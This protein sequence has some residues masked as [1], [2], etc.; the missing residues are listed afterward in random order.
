MQYQPEI[1]GLRALAVLPVILFHAGFQGF[2]G[3]FIGV[4]IFFV[5]S[6]YLITSIILAE[7]EAGTFTLASFYER[8]ARRILPALFFVMALCLPFAWFWLLPYDLQNFSQSLV[9]VPTFA[10][11]IF[12]YQQ[13]GYFDE[14]ASIKPLLHTW[15]L[16]VEEQY[17]LVFP[18][19]IVLTWRFGKTLILKCLV[20]VFILSLA[21]AHWSF[22]AHPYF[23]FFLL[24]T[25]G[26]ELLIGGILA[27]YF[28]LGYKRT[29]N[30][31]INEFGSL[32]GIVLIIH[33]IFLF[34]NATPNPSFYTLVPTV[35]TV[36]IIYFAT[37]QTYT[38][39]LLGSKFFVGLGLI[40]YSAYLY[41][42][43]LFAFAKQRSI[44]EPSK[45][46]IGLLV[47]V[48]FC[49][50]Y[51]SWRFI[52]APFRNKGRINRKQLFTFCILAS[53]SFVLIGL[54][55]YLNKGFPK[56]VNES[57]LLALAKQDD[58]NPREK[59]CQASDSKWI[60]PN[61]SCVMGDRNK[62]QVVLLG[63]SHANAIAYELGNSLEVNGIGMRQLT[64]DGCPPLFDV[65]HVDSGS[66]CYLYSDAAYKFVAQNKSITHIVISLRWTAYL[67]GYGFNNKEGGIEYINSRIDVISEGKLQRNEDEKRREVLK[68]IYAKT[69]KKYMDLGRQVILVYQVPEV[70]WNVP[71]VLAKNKFFNKNTSEN[72][73]TTNHKVYLERNKETNDILDGLGIHKNLIRIKPD[74]IMCDSF[75]SSRCVATFN[76]DVFYYDDDHL[77]NAGARLITREILKNIF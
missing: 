19:F 17:Y 20:I 28:S 16:A 56:R 70:G 24:P 15:S 47:I 10:S 37:P 76:G 64:Y 43:P 69:I 61:D 57:A 12:F 3:G 27:F 14:N 77:S 38:G 66:K 31:W 22:S 26:W 62:I 46:L 71:K 13:S 65:Y 44:D 68:S 49:L 67:K 30:R 35:G 6:G 11:N 45:L 29:E 72:E 75:I 1:D 32:L 39:K 54:V 55:G 18:L 25:R 50:A 8:R 59:E 42:Q 34:D 48:S 52:E 58:R 2:S 7:M 60:S 5:I 53:F 21:L 33:S 23:T 9:A 51:F 74:S 63:D 36:L 40:S 4:D 41:H 73:I